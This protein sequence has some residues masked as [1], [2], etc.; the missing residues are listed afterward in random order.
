LVFRELE[1]QRGRKGRKRFDVRALR[2]GEK[3]TVQAKGWGSGKVQRRGLFLRDPGEVERG[4]SCAP[5]PRVFPE[6]TRCFSFCCL[7]R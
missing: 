7:L 5:V 2:E 1:R 4:N 6:G 3:R